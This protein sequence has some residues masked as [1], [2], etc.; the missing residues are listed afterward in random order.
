MH[1]VMYLRQSS[2]WLSKVGHTTRN[3]ITA[4]FDVVTKARGSAGKHGQRNEF[5]PSLRAKSLVRAHL[6]V[7]K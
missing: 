7:I 1:D 2:G 4:I 3:K 6:R 5:V